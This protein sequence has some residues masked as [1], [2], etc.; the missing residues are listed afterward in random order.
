MEKGI[1]AAENIPKLWD[2]LSDDRK[3][4]LWDMLSDEQ[5]AEV[6]LLSAVAKLNKEQSIIAGS[7]NPVNIIVE[8]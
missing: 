2:M 8:V 6:S 5:K 3:T 1:V 7:E 4:E